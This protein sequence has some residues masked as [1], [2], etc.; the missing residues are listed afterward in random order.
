MLLVG[1]IMAHVQLNMVV[2]IQWRLRN[3]KR[4]SLKSIG[5]LSFILSIMVWWLGSYPA[6]LSFDSLEIWKDVSSSN[7]GDAHTFT[8]EFLIYL[9]SIGGRF[10]AAATLVQS[11]LLYVALYFSV[12]HFFSNWKAGKK[13]LLTSSLYVTPFFGPYGVTLWKDTV[14]A[15]LTIIGIFLIINSNK[16]NSTKYL[17]GVISLTLGTLCRHE[18]WL[19]LLIVIIVLGTINLCGWIITERITLLALGIALLLVLAS[20]IVI[21]NTESIEKTP[22]WGKYVTLLTEIE[23]V[24]SKYPEVVNEV[25]LKKL[26]S[27]SAGLS[28]EN[29][30]KCESING[31]IYSKGFS[32]SMAEKYS[33]QIPQIW[34][35]IAR[36]GGAA[37]L[38]EARYCRINSFLPPPFGKAPKHGY[39]IDNGIVQPNSQ[40]LTQKSLIPY[41]NYLLL[42]WSFLWQANGSLIAWPG[43]Q[44]LI[45]LLCT[46][47]LFKHKLLS[48]SHF[49]LSTFLISRTFTLLLTAVAQDFRY[50][51]LLNLI[52]IP[53]LTFAVTKYFSKEVN[54]S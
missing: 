50:Q 19:T 43:L 13:I 35:R 1:D 41:L 9:F 31:M 47:F 22:S 42:F 49:L 15:S 29:I 5:L 39:W 51:F 11:I 36:S 30:K 7:F 18:A 8:Y 12:G 24:A 32:S 23:Y 38:G 52:S 54:E 34:L 2:G 10:L 44:L 48:K 6:I 40:N 16:Y 45:F 53:L 33:N 14:F 28:F 46:G 21:F 3:L 4:L 25:D 26:H 27:I 20:N 37:Y 17:L